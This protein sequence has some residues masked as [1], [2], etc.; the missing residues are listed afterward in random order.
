VLNDAT[1]D[2]REDLLLRVAK[3]YYK[4]HMFA[5]ASQ[6]FSQLIED[7]PE[8]AH[9][10]QTILAHGWSLYEQEEYTKA[11]HEFSRAAQ[12]DDVSIEAEY[13]LGLVY[14]AEQDW[15]K[16]T[17]R[18]VPLIVIA[19]AQQH[20]LR[21]DIQFYAAQSALSA[22]KF[23]LA[24][25]NFYHWKS[26]SVSKNKTAEHY[27]QQ[28]L[29]GLLESLDALDEF[30]ELDQ[31]FEK[32]HNETLPPQVQVAVHQIAANSL[33]KRKQYN[34]VIERL[35]SLPTAL[36]EKPTLRYLLGIAYQ[37]LGNHNQALL[38]FPNVASGQDPYLKLQVALAKA[39]SLI[40]KKQYHEAIQLLKSCA[41]S[42]ASSH[43]SVR[44]RAQLA[45][46]YAKIGNAEKSMDAYNI[47]RSEVIS[48]E[49]F[50]RVTLLL[51]DTFFDAK[52]YQTS[53]KFYDILS[54]N[55]KSPQDIS[56]GRLGRAWCQD[57]LGNPSET[58]GIIDVLLS[59]SPLEKHA[60]EALLMRGRIL[61]NTN[62]IDPAIESYLSIAAK[63]P[64]SS[65]APEGLLAGAR[66]L[67]RQKQYIEAGRQ[68]QFLVESYPNFGEIITSLYEWAWIKRI[69]KDHDSARDLFVRVNEESR[70]PTEIWADATYRLAESTLADDQVDRGRELIDSILQRAPLSQAAPYSFLLK[71]RIALQEKKW[72]EV[73]KIMRSLLETYPNSPLE[74]EAKYWL[75][76]SLFQ[77]QRLDESLALF[78]KLFLSFGQHSL[79]RSS[80]IG[81]RRSQIL[82]HQK[83]WHDALIL[84]KDTKQEFPN[85]LRKNEL[86]YLIGRCHA[87]LAEFDDARAA[88]EDA[89]GGSGNTKSETSAMSRWMIGESYMH[90]QNYSRAL[91]EY[92]RCEILYP[93]PKWK[94]ASL[95]Q[96]GKCCEMLNQM[97]RAK[98]YYLRVVEEFSETEFGAKAQARLNSLQNRLTL[99]NREERVK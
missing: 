25:K 94:S 26:A 67:S 29:V 31:L 46:C 65:H 55:E 4:N 63:Y 17:N 16:A 41:T 43:S 27:R 33:L 39:N 40:K 87:A 72:S 80:A 21:D 56:R 32:I 47:F 88:Y 11:A 59:D 2:Q 14:R 19:Q 62:Q 30:K 18:L 97:A 1:S 23:Q 38:V 6:F 98:S 99:G 28:A 24:K 71:G 74:E 22:G 76:E 44:C 45:I 12:Y 82:A 79:E 93:Y 86:D 7:Y 57:R 95:L 73:A 51:A 3:T 84:A 35:S 58:L 89:I 13:W 42:T 81:L 85:S 52:Y 48:D 70:E 75:A 53:Y 10:G 8:S 50:S 96:A 60:A 91:Q 68:Y 49:L 54:H 83:K 78:D 92:L 77:Q 34:R 37:R 66:L 9:I 36:E 90:Q 64:D 69:L 61:E 20:A 5:K 15:V